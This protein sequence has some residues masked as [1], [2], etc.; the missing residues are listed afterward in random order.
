MGSGAGLQLI[1]PSDSRLRSKIPLL[2]IVEEEPWLSDW[3]RH[4]ER[5]QWV[6]LLHPFTDVEGLYLSNGFVPI[7]LSILRELV[8]ERVIEVLAALQTLLLEGDPGTAEEDIRQFVVARQL[9]H[10]PITVSGYDPKDAWN[11][12]ED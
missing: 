10:H 2:Y 1:C 9:V 8:E 12:M 11:E 3:K 5:N 4:I 7:I 6:Q